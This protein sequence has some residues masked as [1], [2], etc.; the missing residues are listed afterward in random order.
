M[1]HFSDSDN[2]MELVEDDWIKDYWY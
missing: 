2:N 1:V